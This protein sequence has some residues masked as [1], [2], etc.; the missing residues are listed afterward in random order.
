M[1][2]PVKQYHQ[3][4]VETS[5]EAASPHQIIDMLFAGARARIKQAQ[6]CMLRNDQAGKANSINGCVEILSGLQAS[7]DHEKGGDIAANLESLY[8]YMQRRLFRANADNDVEGLV[9][10]GDL[11]ATL[12]SAWKAIDPNP[13]DQ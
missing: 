1:N 8:D 10:V 7:L 4:D 11:L 2:S 6:G 3:L 9:E 12:R 13:S 5:V